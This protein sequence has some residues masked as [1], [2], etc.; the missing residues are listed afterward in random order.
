MNGRL[1]TYDLLLW[2]LLIVFP[3]SCAA[4]AG[5]DGNSVFPNDDPAF[6]TISA[7]AIGD[8][9]ATGD[10]APAFTL[11][12][13]AGPE[14]QF[15]YVRPSLG[16]MVSTEGSVYGWLGLNLDLFL[17]NRIVLTPQFGVGAFSA[18]DGQSLGSVFEM[19]SGA[20]LAWRFDNRS[21]LGVGLH[22]LSNEGLGD[23]NPGAETLSAYFSL[24]FN[25]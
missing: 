19:R 8:Q 22:H 4:A 14:L 21:R 17:G 10:P 16:L 2:V 12:Y 23:R 6:I 15:L 5:E 13:R 18:G 25:M 11:A 9:F 3:V 20:V 24:P 1:S 7:G